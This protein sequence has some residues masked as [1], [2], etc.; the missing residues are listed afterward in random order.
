MK[1]AR[2]EL[3]CG[4]GRRESWRELSFEDVTDGDHLVTKDGKREKWIELQD[5]IFR[6]DLEV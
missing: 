5:E 2:E 4:T 3:Q 1:R 6:L